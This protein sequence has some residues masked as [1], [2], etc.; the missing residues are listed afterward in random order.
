MSEVFCDDVKH[1]RFL[2]A[3]GVWIFAG[4]ILATL[5]GGLIYASQGP[6]DPTTAT[7]ASHAVVVANSAIIVFRE[8]LEAVLIF[9]AVTA[10]LRGL[11]RPVAAGAAV[12]FAATV[13]T[14]FLAQAILGQFTQYGDQLQAVTGLIAIAVLLVVMNWFFHKVYWTKWIG[15]HNAQRKRVLAGGFVGGQVVG[16]VALGFSSVYREGFEVV[17]FLQNLQLQA[18]TA[19]VLEG[20]AIGLAGTAAVGVATFFLQQKL[21]YKRMLVVTGVMLGLVL[22]VM[23]GGS[24]RTMQ[25]VGWLPSTPVGVSFPGWW[26]RWFEVVPTWETLGA[27]VFA[28]VVVVG[29]YFAAEQLK[30]RRPR[31]RGEEPAV[32]AVQ[33]AGR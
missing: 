7:D 20:V 3:W 23:V 5:V 4:A 17:L 25:D 22:V 1:R 9:A 16:L 32:R 12:A 30:V 31:R 13:A 8:G 18:G 2:Q 27:Q 24:A 6:A 11:R 15:K 19:T 10:S 29:S 28:A 26:A 33:P 14:W 21:P